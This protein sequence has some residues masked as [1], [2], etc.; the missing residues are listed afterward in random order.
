[1]DLARLQDLEVDH[2]D[3][4]PVGDIHQRQPAPLAFCLEL[5]VPG[6]PVVHL[7][8]SQ[9]IQ[10]PAGFGGFRSGRFEFE[11]LFQRSAG[12][13]ALSTLKIAHSEEIVGLVGTG[14]LRPEPEELPEPRLDLLTLAGFELELG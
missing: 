9:K 7:T 8:L 10:D 14:E 11:R 5:F 2:P 6:G 13:L 4:G 3:A 12:L 1:M